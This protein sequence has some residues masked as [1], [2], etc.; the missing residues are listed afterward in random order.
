MLQN[1]KA[2]YSLYEVH[3]SQQANIKAFACDLLISFLSMVSEL[4]Y[5]RFFLMYTNKHVGKRSL[6]SIRLEFF[7]T[8]PC[9]LHA[10][11]RVHLEIINAA[12]GET[13]SGQFRYSNM[14][15]P[16]NLPKLTST[17]R[18][19]TKFGKHSHFIDRNHLF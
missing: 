7:S 10:Q 16:R 6:Y 12:G 1:Q 4:G 2:A 9:Y 5:Q 13:H 3:A 8:A 11:C 18:T 14:S 19:A 17:H 15:Q